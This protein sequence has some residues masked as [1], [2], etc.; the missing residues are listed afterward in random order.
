MSPHGALVVFPQTSLT[1]G[2]FTLHIPHRGEA[3]Y[4]KVIWRR[5]DRAGV[6]LSDMEKIEMPFDTARRLRELEAENRCLHGRLD[7]GSC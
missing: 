1:P 6:T 5:H 7:P 3:H 2:E 4:A